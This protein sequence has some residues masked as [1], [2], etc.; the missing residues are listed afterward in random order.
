MP[1][2]T[3]RQRR[4][5]TAKTL[6]DYFAVSPR[7]IGRWRPGG[8]IPFVVTPGGTYRYDLLVVERALLGL[9]KLTT[10]HG[11]RAIQFSDFRDRRSAVLMD[12]K[13]PLPAY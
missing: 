6:A 13:L 7:T 11:F 2:S 3:E 10:E 1:L 12:A 8:L 9:Q 4:L 5:V